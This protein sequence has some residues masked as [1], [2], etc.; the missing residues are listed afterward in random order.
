MSTTTEPTPADRAKQIR[1]RLNEI[2][3]YPDTDEA[4]TA[5]SLARWLAMRSAVINHQQLSPAG[6]MTRSQVDLLTILFAASHALYALNASDPVLGTQ[7]AREIRNAWEDGGGVGE[8]LW[9]HLGSA[10]C[11][12]IGPLADELAELRKP[13][14]G[15]LAHADVI[16]SALNQAMVYARSANHRDA[17]R[18]ALGALESELE[19]EQAAT[20]E[21]AGGAA[22]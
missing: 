22:R 8:W 7:A 14:D 13:A 12:E 17:F 16:Q 11:T 2:A 9:E 20:A 18:K 10:A 15:L 4:T 1:D 5:R 19:L 3:P 6:V 21:Q